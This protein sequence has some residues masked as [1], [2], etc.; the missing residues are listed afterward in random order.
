MSAARYNI[1][2]E[3]GAYWE[4]TITVLDANEEVRNLDG[5][6]AEMQIRRLKEDVAPLIT[7]STDS[8]GITIDGPS[9][10][11]LVVITTA[12]SEALPAVNGGWYDFELIDEFG[13]RERLFQGTVTIDR[14]VTR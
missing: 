13:E 2:I 10:G 7:L 12:E 6:T 8:G 3:Q 1:Y 4:R 11:I 5:F 14:E 9:G